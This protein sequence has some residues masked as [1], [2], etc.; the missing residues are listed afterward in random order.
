MEE[1]VVR[2][3][4]AKEIARRLLSLPPGDQGKGLVDVRVDGTAVV[5]L[6]GKLHVNIEVGTAYVLL[7]FLTFAVFGLPPSTDEHRYEWTDEAMIDDIVQKVTAFY[8]K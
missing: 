1:I 3:L 6:R 4:L 5:C 2:H 7:M 8:A